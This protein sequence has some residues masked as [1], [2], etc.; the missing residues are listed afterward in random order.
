MGSA[1]PR[2]I[3]SHDSIPKPFTSVR[4]SWEWSTT[5]CGCCCSED[6]LTTEEVALISQQ[7]NSTTKS[8]RH[9]SNGTPKIKFHA[10]R[11]ARIN[12]HLRFLWNWNVSHCVIQ[13]ILENNPFCNATFWQ[14]FLNYLK[15]IQKRI[16]CCRNL[17]FFLS[18]FEKHVN[19][20]KEV[21]LQCQI[22]FVNF[23]S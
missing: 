13:T 19:F 12:W 6:E 10:W 14:F 23:V 18:V 1:W 11:H 21:I 22:Q 8:C 17:I 9:Y 7:E 5:P 20:V 3:S 4:F 2:I 16:F 15:C